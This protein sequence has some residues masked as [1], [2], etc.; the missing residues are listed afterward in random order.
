MWEMVKGEAS[1]TVKNAAIDRVDYPVTDTIEHVRG[2]VCNA[3]WAM[4]HVG[5]R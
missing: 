3:C 2:E 1:A 4:F 5:K